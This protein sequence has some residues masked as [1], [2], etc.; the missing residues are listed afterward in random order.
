MIQTMVGRPY[1]KKLI[2][3]IAALAL[4]LTH[5]PALAASTVRV[6]LRP[7]ITLGLVTGR[8]DTVTLNA[9]VKTT[10][11]S[12]APIVTWRSSPSSV[13]SVDTGGRLTAKKIGTACVY[14][15]AGK[16]TAKCV[17]T[18]RRLPVRA[19]TLNKKRV[20]LLSKRV[21]VQLTSKPTPSNADN[22]S[23][24]W[25]SSRPSVA[26]VD[27][28]TGSI[29]PLN[30]GVAVIQCR[31]ADGTRKKA[32]CTVVVRPVVPDALTLSAESLPVNVGATASLTATVSPADATD[33]RVTWGS[34]NTSVASVKGGVVTGHKFGKATVTAKT[35][36][37]SVIARCAVSVGYYTTTFRALVIGQENYYTY[38]PLNGPHNDAGMVKSMLVN[39]DF[40][41]GKNVEVTLRENLT[42]AEMHTALNE[43]ATWGVDADDVTY[44]YYSGHGSYDDPGALVG[45]DGST[46]SVDTIRQYLDRL[47]GTVVVM[48]DSCYSG[49]FIRNKSSGATTRPS[50]DPDAVTGRIVS[51]FSTAGA[52]SGLDA[53]T[54]LAASE[55]RSKYRI[56][57]ASASTEESY[58]YPSNEPDKDYSLFTCYLAAGGGVQPGNWEKDA[59]RAD[60]NH[61]GIV[62][63]NELF[64]YSKA[65]VN[66]TVARVNKTLPKY[67]RIK[68]SVRV[69]PSG[70]LFPV[71]QRTP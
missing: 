25:S 15:T 3:L 63:L 10:D 38:N 8:N 42:A 14:A 13:V 62:S 18:V 33:Q 6:T 12:A 54:S 17:V 58:I 51:A 21:G 56:L 45:I 49:W 48:I 34:S 22:P 36:S 11:G 50:V 9:T 39:S 47:P 1:A 5:L 37:G 30:P 68:Q 31:A 64:L 23:V 44:F 19:L 59:L 16:T 71:V 70:S 24:T 7:T 26:S 35:R 46:V 61:N 4:L 20:T 65:Q 66:T 57:T 41:G 27:R 53:K 40:G 67:M 55:F 69:W 52:G 29:T 28:M 32:Y 60:Q 2:A 43:M